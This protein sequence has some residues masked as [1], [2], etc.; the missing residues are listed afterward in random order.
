MGDWESNT[1]CQ[2]G[3]LFAILKG[4][5]IPKRHVICY[6]KTVRYLASQKAGYVPFQ[7]ELLKQGMPNDHV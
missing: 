4:P 7:K 1:L 3:L 6:S 5:V 2:M